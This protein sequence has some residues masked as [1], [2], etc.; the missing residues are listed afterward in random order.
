MPI[1]LQIIAKEFAEKDLIAAC[2]AFEKQYEK[3]EA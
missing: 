2:S 3:R 1:G